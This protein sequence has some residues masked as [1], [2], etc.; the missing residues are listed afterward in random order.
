MTRHKKKDNLWIRWVLEIYVK[1]EEWWEYKPPQQ[2][3]WYWKMVCL[4]KDQM[5]MKFSY[6]QIISMTEYSIQEVYKKMIEV[7]PVVSWNGFVWSR[8]NLPKHSFL[9]WL[10][11]LGRLNN[12]TDRLNNVGLIDDPTCLLCGNERETHNHLSFSCPFSEAV[13]RS[14]LRWLNL[15]C[16][17]RSIQGMIVMVSNSGGSRF[18]RQ[19]KC[20]D[21]CG[22]ISNLVGQE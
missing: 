1:E 6:Q 19:V 4:T 17:D 18:R 11:M 13:I 3:N 7:H 22:C 12:T 8:F 14:C 21:L 16:Q 5:E 20:C 9:C 10:M 15:R 2:C